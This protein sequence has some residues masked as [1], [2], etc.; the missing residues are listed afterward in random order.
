MLEDSAQRKIIT[1]KSGEHFILPIADGTVKLSGRDRGI[2][3]STP[4]RGTTQEG[5]KIS[6]DH[7]GSSEESQPVDE[8]KDDAEARNDF[9]SIAGDFTYRHHVC[10]PKETLQFH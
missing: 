3:K 6:E 2:R 7:Q 10:V 5:V 1:P 9:W 8:T 4:M